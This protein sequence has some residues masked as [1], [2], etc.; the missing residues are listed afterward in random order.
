MFSFNFKK[1]VLI[2]SIVGMAMPAQ[3]GWWSTATSVWSTVSNRID[4]V[5]PTFIKTG[6]NAVA[7][8]VTQVKRTVEKQIQP[9]TAVGVAGAIGA[10]SVAAWYG[11]RNFYKHEV[12][13]IK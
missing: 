3:A 1:Y 12:I 5:T 11:I 7:K 13:K 8:G 10:L 6:Y 9:L 4:Q 2:I